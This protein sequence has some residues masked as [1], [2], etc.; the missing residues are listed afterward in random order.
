VLFLT[1]ILGAE[2]VDV[3][4]RRV[5]RVRDVTVHVQEPYPVVTGLVI[6][7][8]RELVVPW[9]AVRTFAARE[10]ALR[11]TKEELERQR[12]SPTNA[13]LARDILDK[14]IIDT[15]GRRVVRVNDLQ[16]TETG[17]IMLLVGADIGIRGILRRLGLEGAGK[18]LMRLF[19]RDLPM[20]LVSWDV[21]DPLPGGSTPEPHD[22][23]KLR[24]AGKRRVTS[25]T[26]SPYFSNQAC[27]RSSSSGVSRTTLPYLSRSGRP[28]K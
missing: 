11:V 12:A 9:S 24:I 13:W 19:G 23:L 4:Q 15:D 2:V 7:R 10:V 8:R 14:Q 26:Q 28:P 18:A 20:V 6:S 17:A 16:L 22:A 1:E 25:T 3:H 21:V 27:P 5:G